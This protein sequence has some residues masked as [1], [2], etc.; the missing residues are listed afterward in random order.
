MKTGRANALVVAMQKLKETMNR[1]PD[2]I[3]MSDARIDLIGARRMANA[4]HTTATATGVSMERVFDEI[5]DKQ[6][7]LL[8]S[9][10][11]I[12]YV[13][14]PK[15]DGIILEKDNNLYM[16]IYPGFDTTFSNST[17]YNMKISWIWVENPV[18]KGV[19]ITLT[20]CKGEERFNIADFAEHEYID[21]TWTSEQPPSYSEAVKDSKRKIQDD[22]EEIEPPKKKQK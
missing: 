6:G 11:G 17:L 14:T 16:P 10:K 21:C 3:Y 1:L 4:A 20:G 19:K 22:V 15:I 5:L 12:V 2:N 9:P 8:F 13:D 7:E 18:G